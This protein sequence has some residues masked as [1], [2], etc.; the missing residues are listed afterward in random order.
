MNRT[1]QTSG[2][3]S[4]VEV[5]IALTIGLL[6]ISGMVSVFAGN[7]QSSE[8][9]TAIANMQESARYALD[10]IARDIRT[11]GYQGCL[12]VQSGATRIRASNGVPTDDFLASAATAAIIGDADVWTPA[13]PLGF[14]PADH[15]AIPGTHAISLQFGDPDAR[16]LRAEMSIAGFPNEAGVIM[17]ESRFPDANAGDL[18]IISNCEL[19]DLFAITATAS[20]GRDL[21]HLPLLNGGS[22]NLSTAYGNERTREQTYVMLFRSNVYYVGDTGQINTEGAA[23][24]ALFRQTLPYG[25]SANNPPTE[26]VTGIENM[27]VRFG[28]RQ[29]GD[30]LRYVTPDS[31]EFDPRRVEAVQI[32]LLMA[33]RDPIADDNDDKTYILAGQ[34]VPPASDPG[35]LA[36][37]DPVPLVGDTHPGDRRYRLAFNTTVKIR[38]RRFR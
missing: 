30:N 7:R 12:E 37:G 16:Q 23:V 19:A 32:G 13:A 15:E 21:L 11:A 3:F 14:V 18:A 10:A 29:T 8:L 9:N 24:Q 6:L 38:N 4:L 31:A 2:G 20:D 5:L 34:S 17:L 26:L 22:G 35:S 28:I 25:D 36:P 33:S 1:R 27:R